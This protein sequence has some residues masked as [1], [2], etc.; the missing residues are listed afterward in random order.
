MKKKSIK[1]LSILLLAI[2]LIAALYTYLKIN[3][4]Q[5]KREVVCFEELAFKLENGIS[6]KEIFR[7]DFDEL[8]LLVEYSLTARSEML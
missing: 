3:Y 1:K 6:P 2:I 5:Q 7:E 8:Q 4:N